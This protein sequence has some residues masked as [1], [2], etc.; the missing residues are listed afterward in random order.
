MKRLAIIA[1]ALFT[2]VSCEDLTDLNDNP[3]VPEQVPA[4]A[5]IANALKEMT[6][7]MSSTNVNENVWR[8]WAQQWSQVT[9]VDESNYELVERDINGELWNTMYARAIRDLEE[10]RKTLEADD[11]ISAE[12]KKNQ[13]AMIEVLEVFAY[14]VLVDIFGDVPYEQALKEDAPAYTD[15]AT[16][17]DDLFAR[18]EDAANKLSGSTGLGAADLIYGGD[19]DAWS[20]FANT[21]QLRMAM[22]LRD[23][24]QAKSKAEAEEAVGRGVFMSMEDAARLNYQSAPPNTN[25]LWEDLV[26]SRRTDFIASGTFGDLLNELQDPRREFFFRNLS[27]DSVVGPPHGEPGAYNDHSQPSDILENPELPGELLGYVETLFNLADAAQLG[28]SV[29]GSAKDF[30]E[31]AITESM[32]E[33]EMYSETYGDGATLDANAISTYL[34]QAE[35]A[36]DAGNAEEL[37]G[38]QKYIAMYNRPFEAYSTWRLYD[39][40]QLEQA[41]NA[42][43]TPPT[44]FTYPVDEFT[45]N[46]ANVTSANNKIQEVLPPGA[47]AGDKRFGK[48]FWDNQ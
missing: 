30:Y 32:E 29:G 9:Y 24:D 44:R 31:D 48:V 25:P 7:I 28:Y 11:I 13:L 12:H 8:L 40:P 2:T 19:A 36:W 14:H 37:I 26:Q 4:D 16:I 22:R 21:L 20:L 27:N 47:S 3:K 6:D 34:G 18:L 43:T 1:L 10:A 15:A 33:W 41:A 35:V 5:L 46:E 39:Y 38:T 23:V 45:L 17:Y 42:G